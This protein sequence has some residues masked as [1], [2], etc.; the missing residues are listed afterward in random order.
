MAHRAVPARS[1]SRARTLRS[2]MTEAEKRIWYRLRGHRFDRK[3]FR[4]QFPIGPYI[5]DFVCLESRLIIEIDGGQHAASQRDKVREIWL[6]SQGFTVLRFWN[7]D[8]LSNIGG[9]LEKIAGALNS[10][11]PPSLTLPRKGGG[12]TPA[13]GAR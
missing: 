8:V 13:R 2:G 9:V 10:S 1:R 3:S 5:V 7:N 4:R 12:N 6:Q 11:P